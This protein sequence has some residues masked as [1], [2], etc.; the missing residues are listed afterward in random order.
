MS[1]K[2][3]T[4]EDLQNLSELIFDNYCFHE[5]ELLGINF[6]LRSL[7]TDER[8]RIFRKYKYFSKNQN[9][10]LIL[11]ILSNSLMY[12][13]GLEFEK[14][15]HKHFLSF[16]SLKIILKI[17]EEYQ[18]N[19]SKI[20]NSSKFI[21][22]YIETRDSRSSWI[23]FKTCSRITDP[24]SIKKLNQYQ[25]YW[26]LMN[27]F[28][29]S[30]EE[31]KRI[32]SKVEYM[33][34]SICAFV[35][36]KAFRKSKDQMSIVEQLEESEDK[37]KK[38]IIEE[39]EQGEKIEVKE[40]NDVFSSL[41][42]MQNES[43]EEHES[44]VNILMEKTLK[45]ELVDEHDRLVRDSELEFL[46]K[47]LREK[48]TQ[49]LVER[50]VFKRQG[51]KFDSVD[52]LENEVLKIQLE[53]DKKKGFFF[54]DFSYLEIVRMRDFVTIP[55][56]EKEKAFEEVMQE[57]INIDLEVEHFLKNLSNDS[58]HDENVSEKE[59]IYNEE[60]VDR[61]SQNNSN[62]DS[63]EYIKK[64]AAEIAANMDVDIK[65]INLIEQRE[66]KIKK[67]NNIMQN[68]NKEIEDSG[69]DQISFE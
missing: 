48:R 19:E 47:F 41:E 28:K 40:S 13:N 20:E 64:S 32:W 66:N 5:F 16:F 18:K 62:R 63:K 67:L 49:V 27:S 9:I 43:E 33:T 39:F 2:K 26:I 69:L 61:D 50:E 34:N 55:K 8:E 35:N 57:E 68:R 3:V 7:K 29:D 37:S 4:K 6:I 23:V 21:D 58:K 38:K 10:S 22:Y 14:E 45:G 25:Y 46:K 12:I 42:K 30:F 65:G 53:E 51:T 60:E 11:E 1:S 31:E 15:K 59:Y 17:F 56:N 36:P 54:E 52:V 44:R 24:F